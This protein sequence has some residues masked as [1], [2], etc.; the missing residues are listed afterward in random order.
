MEIP[1]IAGL[2]PISQSTY[3]ILMKGRGRNGKHAQSD[4]VEYN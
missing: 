2:W 1:T 3:N 4:N